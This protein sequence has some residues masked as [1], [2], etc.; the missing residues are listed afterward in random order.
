M[1]GWRRNHRAR[2]E[3]YDKCN[4]LTVTDNKTP[5]LLHSMLKEIHEYAAVGEHKS[6][7]AHLEDAAAACCMA[8]PTT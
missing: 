5:D 1:G 2:H 3:P 8:L 7:M 4:M 6:E